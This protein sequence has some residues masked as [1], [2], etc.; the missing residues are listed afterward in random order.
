MSDLLENPP[1]RSDLPVSTV[2]DS[3][4]PQV[5]D[6]AVYLPVGHPVAADSEEFDQ[7]LRRHL[8][9]DI[10][11]DVMGQLHGISR[12]ASR[13]QWI[14][15]L[16]CLLAAFTLL[17]YF[18]P[19]TGFDELKEHGGMEIRDLSGPLPVNSPYRSVFD[20]ACQEYSKG[21]NNTVCRI[22]AS[23]VEEIIR[24]GDRKSDR[25]LCLYFK[26]V[27]KNQK[28]GLGSAKAAGQLRQ[29]ILQDRDN[30]NWLE[31]DFDLN[32]R[33][34]RVMNYEDVRRKLL[35]P[36]S[37]VYFNRY[38]H[39]IN[40]ALSRLTELKRTAGPPK[41]T[42]AEMV[43]KREFF[44]LCNVKLLLSCWL[45][46]GYSAG[47]NILPDNRDDPGVAEREKALQ[48]ALKHRDSGFRDFWEARLFI[49]E[50]LCEHDSFG[51]NKLKLNE[52]Y[53][54][55]AYRKSL[56]E[57]KLEIRDCRERLNGGQ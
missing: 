17:Y 49:A 1:S 29:L 53:W 40:Y 14:V 34:R 5:I 13:L 15:S 26:A 55:G 8:P 51:L 56:D 31:F 3:A 21:N 48:I 37:K 12:Q 24:T 50:T 52:I 28:G 46:K 18:F 23:S 30:P 6:G 47:K 39:D 11:T 33:I 57:L 54:N 43:T 4:L 2:P 20:A 27:R 25:L 44:D 22:L 42:R 45:L 16:V 19:K 7:L 10:S 35:S 32:P 41:Y 9:P 36:E 38:P